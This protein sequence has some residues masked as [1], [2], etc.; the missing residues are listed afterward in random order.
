ML[1]HLFRIKE[2]NI[3]AE[4]VLLLVGLVTVVVCVVV[5]TVVPFVAAIPVVVSY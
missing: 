3:N 5:V 1:L 2:V 4:K